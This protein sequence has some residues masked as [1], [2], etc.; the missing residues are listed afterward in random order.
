MNTH[1]PLKSVQLGFNLKVRAGHCVVHIRAGKSEKRK[2]AE[3]RKKATLVVQSAFRQKK[4]YNVMISSHS[5][6]TSKA[7]QWQCVTDEIYFK[8]D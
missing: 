3:S 5:Y 4:C 1:L 2:K 7:C 8:Q 6:L